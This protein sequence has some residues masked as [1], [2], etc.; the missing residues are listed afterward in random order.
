[1][2]DEEHLQF[3]S[4]VADKYR[5]PE[6]SFDS[7]EPF[8]I[9]RIENALTL[10]RTPGF[11]FLAECMAARFLDRCINENRFDLLIDLASSL[12]SLD[13][14]IWEAAGD[15]LLSTALQVRSVLF[16]AYLAGGCEAPQMIHA[17]SRLLRLALDVT[18]SCLSQADF[19]LTH[20]HRLVVPEMRF[21]DER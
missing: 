2:K 13:K 10:H 14:I 12:C 19:I 4:G 16:W 3:L 15:H 7:K 9:E 18:P 8:S 5:L 1:M 21:R 20:P 6:G 11:A 17:A